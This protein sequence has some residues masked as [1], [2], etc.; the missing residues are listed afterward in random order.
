MAYEAIVC[1]IT[2]NPHPDP[3]VRNL[4]VGT[5]VGHTVIVGKHTPNGT[6]GVFFPVD[7]AMSHFMAYHNNLYRKGKGTN[8][9]PEQS[10]YFEENR[11]IRTQR[12]RKV[13]SEGIWLPLE[14]LAW[15][16]VDLRTLQVGQMFNTLNG[17]L[18]CEKYIT[19]ATRNA[20][21]KAKRMRTVYREMPIFRE[22]YDTPQLRFVLDSIPDGA[23]I[24]ITEKLH[25]TSGRS[26]YGQVEALPQTISPWR[27]IWNRV[28]SRWAPWLPKYDT[29]TWERVYGTRRVVR[30]NSSAQ[31]YYAGTDFRD[32]VHNK[33][34][35]AKGMTAYYEI[36]GYTDTGASIMPSHSL[37]ND[38][39][40]KP[41]R[42]LYGDSVTYSYGCKPGEF[43]FYIY[44]L[45]M[46][47]EDGVVVEY[48]HDAVR[49]WCEHHGL[50]CVP[51]LA[52]YVIAPFPNFVVDPDSTI[53]GVFRGA[54]PTSVL[55]SEAARYTHGSS[56]LDN[57]HIRE[58]VCVR[59]EHPTMNKIY[60]LKGWYFSHLEGIT[61]NDA[62]YVDS[63][64]KEG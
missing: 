5:V 3:E 14:A 4:A 1:E 58:G 25:G 33:I 19:P 9:D 56:M 40:L 39:A 35:L 13:D 43:D 55:L 16:G 28:T 38:D 29:K 37:Q 42:K 61:K 64:E 59:V 10:G 22:H 53:D 36:V 60:K 27:R 57:T 46:T 34:P 41:L 31:D 49:A 54:V 62:T 52:E 8:I 6:I 20:I 26:C 47:N 44:R 24:I 7:G 12:F 48:T 17:Q 30:W 15:T 21:A 2:V 63:E 51:A 32:I 23:R 18:V 50:K 45:T 11:R